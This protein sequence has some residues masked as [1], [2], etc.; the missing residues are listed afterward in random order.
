[1]EVKPVLYVPALDM[2]IRNVYDTT[3]KVE[4]THTYG[5]RTQTYK[6]DKSLDPSVVIRNSQGEVMAEGTAPFG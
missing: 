4:K 6:T 5:D 2:M 3:E 1:V